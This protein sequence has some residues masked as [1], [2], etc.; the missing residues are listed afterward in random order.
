MTE[1][2]E[3]LASAKASREE[4]ERAALAEGTNSLW[5]D[6]VAKVAA[7]LTWSKSSPALLLSSRRNEVSVRDSARDPRSDSYARVSFRP[8]GCRSRG[9]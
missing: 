2:L 9:T 8:L 5:V 7:G 3:Q 6:G 1:R 4:I